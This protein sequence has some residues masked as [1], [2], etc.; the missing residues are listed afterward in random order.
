MKR[1]T[2][3]QKR[4]M[5][6]QKWRMLKIVTRAALAIETVCSHATIMQLFCRVS[7]W[8]AEAFHLCKLCGGPPAC[9]TLGR[10]P[11]RTFFQSIAAS[12]CC[13][14]LAKQAAGKLKRA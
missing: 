5:G 2:R 4:K 12:M 9:S 7:T 11:S 10:S 14:I 13:E 3:E 1:K 8:S 6:T